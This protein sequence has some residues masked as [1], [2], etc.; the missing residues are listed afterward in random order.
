M[1][2][3]RRYQRLFTTEGTDDRPVSKPALMASVVGASLTGLA[4][5]AYKTMY[6]SAVEPLGDGYHLFSRA[7]V[8]DNISLGKSDRH[9]RRLLSDIAWGRWRR[10]VESSGVG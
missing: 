6:L 2:P 10:K 4:I 8:V 9:A 5:I 3:T 7:R 1:A